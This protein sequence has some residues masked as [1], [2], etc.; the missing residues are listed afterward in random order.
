[1]REKLNEEGNRE[2][3]RIFVKDDDN[4]EGPYIDYQTSASLEMFIEIEREKAYKVGM[5][6]ERERIERGIE[7]LRIP[8]VERE[9]NDSV[10][11]K[12]G[13]NKAVDQALSMVRNGHE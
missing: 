10:L 11:H 8:L 12:Y 2:F 7:A 3:R 5:Q 1:M 4:F 13:F 9:S 6:E